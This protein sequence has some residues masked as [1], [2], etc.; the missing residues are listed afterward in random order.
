[1]P[2]DYL[3]KDTTNMIVCS[4]RF[5]VRSTRYFSRPGSMRSTFSKR[6]YG[7]GTSSRSAYQQFNNAYM[8]KPYTAPQPR[9]RTAVPPLP[10]LTTDMR[11]SSTIS[12]PSLAH[13]DSKS[14]LSADTLSPESHG[15]A[16]EVVLNKLDAKHLTV[17]TRPVSHRHSRTN[18]PKIEPSSESISWKNSKSRGPVPKHQSTNKPPVPEPTE[19]P[20]DR[21]SSR[22]SGPTLMQSIAEGEALGVST[23]REAKLPSHQS[24]FLLPLTPTSPTP[25]LRSVVRKWT[26]SDVSS[27]SPSEMERGL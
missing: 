10:T 5:S 18:S 15:I 13:L 9:P 25:S 12:R 16:E 11:P 17:T 3:D 6:T 8:V 21:P 2:S 4:Q 1:M 26:R 22:Q 20:T 14:P 27:L 19:L 7:N 24:T 23:T